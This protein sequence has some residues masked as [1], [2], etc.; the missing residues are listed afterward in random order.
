MI[1]LKQYW[2]PTYTNFL[3]HETGT[4]CIFHFGLSLV[5]EIDKP[6]STLVSDK[7]ECNNGEALC[8]PLLATCT[9]T[10][11]A[12]TCACITGYQGDGI[13]CIG[14]IFISVVCAT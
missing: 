6:V 7:N 10:P 4:T 9:N 11:G 5:L 3:G 2:L 14:K 12:Y 8:H 1:S 13:T